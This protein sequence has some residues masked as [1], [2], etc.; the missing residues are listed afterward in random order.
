MEVAGIERIH[1]TIDRHSF[2]ET[3]IKNVPIFTTF[4]IFIYAFRLNA[5]LLPTLGDKCATSLPF[6]SSQWL[7]NT[8]TNTWFSSKGKLQPVVKA[9]LMATKKQGGVF[10]TLIISFLWSSKIKKYYL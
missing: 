3:T 5:T 1:R 8:P 6:H 7:F 9:P 10:I 4:R 2:L